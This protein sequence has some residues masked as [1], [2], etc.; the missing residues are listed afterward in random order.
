MYSFSNPFRVFGKIV[1]KGNKTVSDLYG[2]SLCLEI[3]LWSFYSQNLHGKIIRG[4]LVRRSDV[5]IQT[6]EMSP[7][8]KTIIVP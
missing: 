4:R 5:A 8:S 6:S 3:T 7:L 1:E 2:K